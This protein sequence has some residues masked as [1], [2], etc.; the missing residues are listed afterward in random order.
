MR[1]LRLA[2]ALSPANLGFAF[3]GLA[4]LCGFLSYPL[5]FGALSLV[6]PR[7]R[8]A[9]KVLKVLNSSGEEHEAGGGELW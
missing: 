9:F 5:P 3:L 8:A 6:S 7:L 1:S 4:L 2:H